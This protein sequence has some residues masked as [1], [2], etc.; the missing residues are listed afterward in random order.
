MIIR[1]CSNG[2][3]CV[4][5]PI[6]GEPTKLAT[7]NPGLACF[8]CEEHRMDQELEIEQG[9]ATQRRATGSRATHERKVETCALRSCERPA[10]A[11]GRLWGPVCREHAQAEG[12]AEEW[13]RRKEHVRDL[14]RN[15]RIAWASADEALEH[16]WEGLLDRADVEVEE[17]KA[18]LRE[19]ERMAVPSTGKAGLRTWL[20]ER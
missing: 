16:K 6:I 10:A 3:E 2:E 7:G 1:P 13:H 8:A 15:L 4:S 9:R 5:Y 19:A 11:S 14:E 17:A 12:A 20:K 18:K